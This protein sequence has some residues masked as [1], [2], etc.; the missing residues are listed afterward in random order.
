MQ[1]FLKQERTDKIYRIKC[2]FETKYWQV[3]DKYRPNYKSPPL[4]SKVFS[5]HEAGAYDADP[6]L[7]DGLKL[8]KA[9]PKVK[10]EWP[11]SENQWYGWFTDP[12]TDRERNDKFMYFPRTS[13]EI[14]RIGVRIFADIKRLKKWN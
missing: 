10:Q 8:S 14:S 1:D 4:S 12:L 13:T 7:L 9:P 6:E 3:Y 2:D 11:E 5:R